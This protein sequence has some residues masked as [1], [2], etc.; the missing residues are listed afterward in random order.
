[1]NYKKD[2]YKKLMTL[3][4]PIAFQQFMLAAVSASDAVMLGAVSQNALSAVSLAGQIQFVFNLFLAALTIGTSMFAA[5][6]WGKGD[7]DS[8]EKILGIVLRVSA[9][10]AIV[11]FTGTL[12]IP[13]YLMRIFT[14][15]QDLI[16]KGVLYLRIVGASYL[17]TGVSQ[18]Y[19]CIMKNSGH[20]AKSTVISSSAVILN[21]VLNAVFIF[22]LLGA[23][24]MGI[25]GAAIATVISR[26]VELLWVLAESMKKGYIK[27]RISY[28]LHKDRLLSKDLWRYTM[29]VL[30]NELVWGCGFTMYSVIMGHLGTD[31]VAANSVANVVKNLIAC[32]CMGLGSGGGIIVGNELGRGELEKARE[33]G[34]RLCEMSIISGLLSGLLLLAL[35]PAIMRAASLS[36]QA[37]DY[38]GW[39]LAMCAFYMVGKSVNSTT[40]AGIFCAGGDSKFG[41]KCDA[42]VMW[43]ITVP[44]GFAAAFWLNLPVAAVYFIVNMDEMIKLPAVYK[45]YKKYIWVKDL[46][47]CR[48]SAADQIQPASPVSL[49]KAESD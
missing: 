15:E 37:E 21:I 1:M 16:E 22:G 35:S 17:L 23:P 29:P 7:T 13:G 38:L 19:L 45:H 44:L 40:I 41:F 3:V 49:R 33:Y 26:C 24:E 5:Q 2:F 48:D 27:I 12:L 46:T 6:Y 30:G 4:I 14:P 8:V 43:L 32:F 18:I 9:A 10:V 39:M 36:T 42:V 20:A 31:A 34:R 25:A 47:R 11:F 28:L